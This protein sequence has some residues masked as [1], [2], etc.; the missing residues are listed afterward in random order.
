MEAAG[1]PTAR[2]RDH[3]DVP[4]ALADLD[5]F[6]PPYVV[7]YDGLAAG[8]GVTVTGDRDAAAAAVRAALDPARPPT[9]RRPRWCS[10]SSW[11]AP[12]CRSSAWS[13]ADGVDRAAQPGT[14]L[15]ASATTATPGRTRVGW[16]PTRRCRGLPSDLSRAAWSG[17]SPQPTVAEMAAGATRPFTGLLFVGLALTPDGPQGHRVQRPLR[18]SGD[19]VGA[20]AARQ[21]AHAAARPVTAG[22]RAGATTLC[23]RPS[24]SPPPATRESPRHRRRRSAGSTPQSAVDGVP[25][26]CMPVPGG[27]ATDRS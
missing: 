9:R 2:G 17:R 27:R 21:P 19:P 3:H 26:C 22:R 16:V 1:V 15:Q 5:E 4:T 10:R 18:G 6:G 24:S 12:R 8:K 11:P 14:G 23:R 13:A 7:K 25:P 20:G